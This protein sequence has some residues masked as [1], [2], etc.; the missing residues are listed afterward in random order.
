MSASDS[1]PLTLSRSTATVGIGF[2]FGLMASLPAWT[3]PAV[4]SPSRPLAPADRLRIWSKIYDQGRTTMLTVVPTGT[5]LLLYS[6]IVA[7]SPLPYLPATFIGRHRKA[8]LA[9]AAAIWFANL[10]WTGLMMEKLNWELKG[11]EEKLNKE[12]STSSTSTAYA[13]QAADADKLISTK[14]AKLHGVRVLLGGVAFV[15]CV[16]ELA[17]A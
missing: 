3:F 6:A 13:S 9:T 7:K 8:V 11:V 15:L 4:Y 12:A 14:W 17:F 2:A 5:A 1:L 10:P 16:A